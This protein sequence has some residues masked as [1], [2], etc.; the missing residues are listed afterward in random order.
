MKEKASIESI[1][2]KTKLSSAELGFLSKELSEV[3][4]ELESC[5][6]ECKVLSEKLIHSQ[7]NAEL[8]RKCSQERSSEIDLLRH[9]LKLYESEREDRKND[10]MNNS[11]EKAKLR[12]KL[13]TVQAKLD[14][15]RGRYSEAINEMVLM[16]KKFKEA[17]TKLKEQMKERLASDGAEI[18]RLKRC[19]AERE[20][21]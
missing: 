19:L 3:R 16:D 2:E 5:K 13:R 17:S 15:F 8:E 4:L 21:D 14:A 12:M 7:K 9:D 20:R 10:M 1:A 11:N 6:G 18:F